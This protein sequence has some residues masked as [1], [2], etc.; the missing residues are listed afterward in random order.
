M[1]N[2]ITKRDVLIAEGPDHIEVEAQMLL[3]L[4]YPIQ[5]WRAVVN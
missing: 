2:K 1:R 4:V 5:V 3:E